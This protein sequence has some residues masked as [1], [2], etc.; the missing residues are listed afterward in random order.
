MSAN[1][2]YSRLMSPLSIGSLKLKNRIILAPM[3]DNLAETDGSCTERIQAYYEARAAGGAGLLIMGVV[4]V[5]FP[6]GTAEPFQTGLSD[7]RFIPGLAEVARRV[8]AAGG[9]IAV[10]LQHA[11]KTAIRD[12]VDGRELWVPSIPAPKQS[13]MMATLT[14]EERAGFISNQIRSAP[15]IRVMDKAD[16]AQMVE[17]FAAAA[18]RAKQA[19]VDGVELHAGHTYI[20]AGFLSAHSNQ[21]DDAYGGPIENRARLMVEVIHAVKARCGADY[22]VWVRLDG[23]EIDFAGGITPDDAVAAARLAEAAGADAIHVSAYASAHRSVNFTRAPLVHAPNALLPLAE[24]VKQA[25][26]VP[27]IGVGRVEPE[28]ADA[29]IGRGAIDAIAMGRKLLADPELPNKLAQGRA[30]E[31][32]PCIYCYTCVS[33]IFVNQS[34]KCAVNPACGREGEP[35]QGPADTRRH[36]VVVGGGP[37]GMEAARTAA[38]RGHRVTLVEKSGRLGGT[39]FFAALAYPENGRLLDYLT[40][41]MRR[42][43]IAVRLSTEATPSLLASLSPDVVLVASGAR[44]GGAS[45]EGAEQSHVFSGDELRALLTGD[46]AEDVARRKLS[47]AQ[48]ALMKAGN[49]SGVTGSGAALQKLSHVWMPLGESVA[50]VGGGL[51]GLEL[52]EFLVARKRKVTVIEEGETLGRELSIVRRWH[53]LGELGKHQVTLLRDTRVR[54]IDGKTL[55][56]EGAEGETRVR[57][58]SVVLA[59]G[60]RGDDSV[61]R[62]LAAAG[63]R[64]ELIG[65]AAGLGYIEGALAA[66]RQAGLA[67]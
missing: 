4:S 17:W 61:A 46:G 29:A 6:A 8:H 56:C 12:L 13:D 33:Q 15:K 11:G 28:D 49:L 54:L 20:L 7:D 35:L 16:I 44:R 21:R 32:R 27:V 52:A 65:D 48:R 47:L 9:K 30:A 26:G 14:P 51:V 53:V 50:I 40:A 57:A 38:L 39:L 22:P 19:G 55:V 23:E 59:S 64:V 25:V 24:R 18:L 1:A 43:P 37:A 63:F 67:A 10:Q 42:L 3:G 45:I 31:V 41:E 62:S 36:V 5:A 60:A 2:P 34:V 58:D 66:G